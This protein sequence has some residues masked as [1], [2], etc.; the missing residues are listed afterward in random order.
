MLPPR[1][2]KDANDEKNDVSDVALVEDRDPR[3]AQ[4]LAAQRA[5]EVGD[6]RRVRAITDTLRT[7]PTDEIARAAADLRKRVSVDPAQLVVL[8][9]CLA[10]FLALVY[11]Y[12]PS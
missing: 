6:Y 9:G 4:L 12:V 10:L 2:S 1:M 11:I 7:P 8:L 5:F 3:H